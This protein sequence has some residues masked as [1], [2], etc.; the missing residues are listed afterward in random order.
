MKGSE[1]GSSENKP[2]Q[3]KK[4]SRKRITCGSKSSDNRIFDDLTSLWI[5]G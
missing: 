5:T 2:L 4:K 3:V 1:L